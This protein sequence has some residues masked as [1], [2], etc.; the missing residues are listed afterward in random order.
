M[1]YKKI[2]VTGGSG[3]VGKSLK[4]IMPNAIYLSSKDCDLTNY[5]EV[6]E[7]WDKYK[8]N[9]VIHLAAK[10]GGI[11]DN[12]NYP[13]DYFEDNILMNTNIMKASR[14][15]NVD[16]LIAILSTCIY[17]DKLDNY[18][19]T[20]DML[21]LGP[22]TPTNF[23]YGYAKRSLAVHIDSYN[24]QYKTK[25]QYLTPCNLYGEFDKYGENS[26]FVAAL[27]KKIELAKNNNQ[28]E[29]NLFGTGKPLRQFMH[30]S[31]LAYIIKYCLD[32]DVYENLNVATEENLSIKQIAEIVIEEIGEG[33]IKNINFDST[34]P[35]GQ[36][37]KDVSI[38]KLNNF[39]LKF[40]PLK[41]RD[42][43]KQT[44]SK[45][46]KNILK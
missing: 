9:T 23:S 42:G 20:E 37:R 21:H 16:R 41:L 44:Y 31:D 35:D 3:M 18:P 11:I 2:L 17:P 8:P 27:I 39:I 12:I 15:N 5:E 43:I 19:I 10:V 4:E 28:E 22:P 7:V 34:K 6:L 13:A 45:I 38:D 30:S 25:Y 32:N 29:I 46:D 1:E 26:H 36:F 33:K 14:L 40:S 24:Q